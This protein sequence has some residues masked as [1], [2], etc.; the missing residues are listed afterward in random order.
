V[1]GGAGN[2]SGPPAVVGLF[3]GT[4]NDLVDGGTGND[5]LYGQEGNDLLKGGVGA[6]SLSGGEDADR[7]IGGVGLD[8]L[9][10]DAG[11]DRFVFKTK[12][13]SGKDLL[14]DRHNEVG[15]RCVYDA[16]THD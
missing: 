6:D 13:D 12:H 2:D 4:G 8:V 15:F 14:T 5:S 11:Q 16:S 3:G 1:Y 9:T 7:L 10:G